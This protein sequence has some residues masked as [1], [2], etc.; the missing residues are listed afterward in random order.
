[1]KGIK[2]KDWRDDNKLKQS[3]RMTETNEKVGTSSSNRTS[4]NSKMVK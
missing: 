1:M 3:E 4:G 2:W